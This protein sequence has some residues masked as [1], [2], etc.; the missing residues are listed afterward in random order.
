MTKTKKTTLRTIERLRD[1]R[2]L[3][4]DQ[5]ALVMG[6][7]YNRT[8]KP[9]GKAWRA[10][11]TGQ[12]HQNDDGGAGD[13]RARL[14]ADYGVS[15]PTIERAGKFAAAVET[16]KAVDPNPTTTIERLRDRLWVATWATERARLERR[17]L[18]TPDVEWLCNVF[19]EAAAEWRAVLAERLARRRAKRR[20]A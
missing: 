19:F 15:Q 20:P 2:N 9:G 16:L 13:T 5:L 17:R 18:S 4:P 12:H 11:Q 1:R 8:K 3:T 10:G 7:H 6:R 14:S